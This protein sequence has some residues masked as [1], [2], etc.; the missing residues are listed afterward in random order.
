MG[1]RLL[2]AAPPEPFLL[3][4]AAVILLYLNLDRLGRGPS[5]IV[6]RLRA[7]LGIGFGSALRLCRPCRRSTCASCS[8]RPCRC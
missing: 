7:P 4:L 6:T 8:A 3:V 2:L 1:T 5:P